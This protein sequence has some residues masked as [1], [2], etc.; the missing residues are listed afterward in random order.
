MF[1]P[2]RFAS[3][4]GGKSRKSAAAEQADDETGPAV[5]IEAPPIIRAKRKDKIQAI[6]SLGAS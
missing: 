4:L 1:F 3:R 6:L 2:F 5:E